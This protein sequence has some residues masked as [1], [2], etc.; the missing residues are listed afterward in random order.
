[1]VSKYMV[2]K[3]ILDG[4]PGTRGVHGLAGLLQEQLQYEAVEVQYLTVGG[5]TY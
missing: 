4:E 3:Y 1:M 5:R 2:S